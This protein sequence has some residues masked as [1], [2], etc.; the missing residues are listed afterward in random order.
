MTRAELDTVRL[1]RWQD[2]RRPTL[3]LMSRQL[4]SRS[5]GAFKWSQHVNYRDGIR[6]HGYPGSLYCVEGS[7]E[8]VIPD[9]CQRLILWSGDLVDIA[10]GVRHG[11]AI[12]RHGAICLESIPATRRATPGARRC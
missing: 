1:V 3:G 8:P 12:G 9:T 2:G 6:S 10:E 4:G 5:L 7:P 11:I